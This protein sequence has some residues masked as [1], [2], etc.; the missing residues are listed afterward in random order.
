MYV[1]SDQPR[2][3]DLY[4]HVVKEAAYK[5]RHLRVELLPYQLNELDII[6]ANWPHDAVR[7]CMNVFQK[8]LEYTANA[9]WDQLIRALRSVQLDSLA[10]QLEQMIIREGEL[11]STCRQSQVHHVAIYFIMGI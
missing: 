6:D 9:S 5:W 4:E 1:G 11:Y 10:V 7:C 8:W 3:R 2:L